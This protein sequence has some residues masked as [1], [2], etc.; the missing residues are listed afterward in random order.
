MFLKLTEIQDDQLRDA[1]GE[2]LE[3]NVFIVFYQGQTL[4]NKVKKIAE[5]IRATIYRKIK[6]MNI[7][8]QF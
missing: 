3:K 5:G 4:E 7:L 2:V 6:I 1:N 8:A